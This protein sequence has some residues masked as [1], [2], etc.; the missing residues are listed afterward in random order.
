MLTAPFWYSTVML[1]SSNL[2]AY[3]E[4]YWPGKII[5]AAR[6]PCSSGVALPGN[7]I[8]IL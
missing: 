3:R 7:E 6:I 5:I 1:L 8:H 2:K 4:G